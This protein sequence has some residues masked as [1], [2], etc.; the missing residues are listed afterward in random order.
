MFPGF[1]P[2]NTAAASAALRKQKL[3]VGWIAAEC[4]ISAE[5][6]SNARMPWVA[7]PHAGSGC[8]DMC[9]SAHNDETRRP[10]GLT[11]FKTHLAVFRVSPR[12]PQSGTNPARSDYPPDRSY[13]PDSG[14]PCTPRDWISFIASWASPPSKVSVHLVRGAS[15][16]PVL[17]SVWQ[18]SCFLACAVC[19]FSPPAPVGAAAQPAASAAHPTIHSQCFVIPD[20]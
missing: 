5:R 7:A 19:V 4:S 15:R 1:S 3:D 10:C 16:D 6:G 14:W 8:L 11:G 2:L 9:L 18:Y 13:W 12:A 20:T 17:S